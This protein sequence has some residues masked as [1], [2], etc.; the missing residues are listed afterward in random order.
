MLA[1]PSRL[2]FI[3]SPLPCSGRRSLRAPPPPHSL[4]LGD[5]TKRETYLAYWIAEEM[6]WVW[7]NVGNTWDKTGPKTRETNG[8]WEISGDSGL[9]RFYPH[10]SLKKL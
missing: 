5:G 4:S 3:S 6:G 8:L 9:G 7:G 1:A 10:Q 2:P